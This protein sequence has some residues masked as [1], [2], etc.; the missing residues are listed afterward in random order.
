M[1]ISILW[2]CADDWRRMYVETDLHCFGI[3][4]KFCIAA[5]IMLYGAPPE[6]STRP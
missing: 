1:S 5:E 3:E 2:K 6:I 4:L